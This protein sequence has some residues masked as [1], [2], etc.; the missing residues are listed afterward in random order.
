MSSRNLWQP[1]IAGFDPRVQFH[2]VMLKPSKSKFRTVSRSRLELFYWSLTS[3]LLNVVII[4][5][6]TATFPYRMKSSLLPLLSF[7]FNSLSD[8]RFHLSSFFLGLPTGLCPAAAVSVS[9]ALL[10]NSSAPLLK[11]FQNHLDL[12]EL[13]FFF[14]SLG[15]T[16]LQ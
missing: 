16:S 9:M 12:W 13:S 10:I 15:N 3:F 6:F 14:R 5:I 2:W 1:L 11:K 7:W 4:N 8:L